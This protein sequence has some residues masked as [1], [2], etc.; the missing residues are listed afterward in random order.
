MSSAASLSGS[1]PASTGHSWAIVLA[2]GDGTRLHEL[3]QRDGVAT[4]KQFCSLVGGRS[5]LRDALARAGRIVPRKRIVVVVAR[6]HECFWERE[7]SDL[8]PDN[9][10][11]QPRNRGTAAG[12][13][14]PVLAVL[15]RDP[16]ARLAVLPSDHF[17]EEE[18]VLESSLR[19]ALQALDDLPSRITLLGL[20]PDAPETGYGWIVPALSE[21]LLRP[22]ELF[23]EKPDARRA[24]ELLARG[25]LWNS[26][27]FVARAANLLECFQERLPG[28][29]EGLV[30]ALAGDRAGRPE[31]LASVYAELETLDF[32]REILQGNERLLR[33]KTVPPCGWTDLGTPER[34]AACLCGLLKRSDSQ[35][36]V[37]D[38][39]AAFDL[40]FA[41]RSWHAARRA[42]PVAA[43]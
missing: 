42:V 8:P 16:E 18:S 26:F 5:L 9:I 2:A 41:V 13:L 14:L 11:V 23:V 28:L 31:R 29:A 1:S 33:L 43:T 21:R 35:P 20:T 38:P 25:A 6:E 34:V 19:Y 4:P 36:V 12:V 27:L 32:S 39:R 22:I 15:E 10:V 37:P 3:T 30:G 7:L 40:A 17:V 24:T